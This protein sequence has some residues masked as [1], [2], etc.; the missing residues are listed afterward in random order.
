[1]QDVFTPA[2]EGMQLSEGHLQISQLRCICY[3][4]EMATPK[5]KKFHALAVSSDIGCLQPGNKATCVAVA[6]L[7]GYLQIFGMRLGTSSVYLVLQATE[8]GNVASY[9]Y[10]H[11]AAV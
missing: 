4:A 10:T 1:M 2:C 8:A 9:I 3:I 5:F 7:P 6:S 11:I